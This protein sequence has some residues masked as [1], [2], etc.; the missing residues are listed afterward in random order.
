MRRALLTT[1]LGLLGIYP[2]MTATAT[3]EAA[4]EGETAAAGEAAAEDESEAEAA[5][6]AELGTRK[7]RPWIRRWAPE[8]NTSELGLYGGVLLPSRRMEL[9]EADFDLPDQGYR[10]FASVAPDFGLRLGYFPIRWFGV[11]AE[12]GAMP[13]RTEN[14]GSALLWTARGALV[15]QLGM[16]TVTPFVLVGGGILG[17]SSDRMAVGNDVDVALHVGGGL[18]VH[19]GRYTHMRLDVRDVVTARRGYNS[20]VTNSAEILLGLGVTLGRE[21]DRAAP[22]PPTDGDGDGIVDPDDQCVKV[23][24]VAA[25][26]GCP[27]P[28]SDGDSILDP[29]DQCKDVPGVAAFEGCPIPDT[30]GD[31]ILDPDDQCKDVP[32][33]AYLQGCPIPDTD[34]DSILDSEDPC[35]YEAETVNGIDDTDG[36]P[37]GIPEEVARF[38]G[39]IEGIVFDTDKATIRKKSTP[40]LTQA[41]EVLRKHPSVRVEISGHTDDRGAPLPNMELSRRRADAVKQ[42]LVDAGI[43]AGRITTRGAGSNEPIADNGNKQGRGKNRRI[44]FKLMTG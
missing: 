10:P 13:A 5:P 24:G 36:C 8:R 44:E 18:K 14:A 11:E 22:P 33:V 38:T 20:G 15:G 35:V 3:G 9:F 7:D 19:L 28:D 34:G 12:G 26:A 27:I 1:T 2:A 6:R 39:V 31:S 23:P 17:V 25:F 43:D 40:V 32:G 16:W 37:D 4:A 29:D 42:W 41:L 21:R 30:D